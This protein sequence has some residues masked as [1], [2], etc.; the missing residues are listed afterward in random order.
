MADEPL[1][2]PPLATAHKSPS[3]AMSVG[4][5]PETDAQS[6]AHFDRRV[7]G[8]AG[9]PAPSAPPHQPPADR[10]P[11]AYRPADLTVLLA[12][13]H[14]ERRPAKQCLCSAKIHPPAPH[15]AGGNAKLS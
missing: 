1:R 11:T 8:F 2:W 6:L 9:E 7:A 10:S 14:E 5:T 3:A 4:G 12:I 13:R 15:P